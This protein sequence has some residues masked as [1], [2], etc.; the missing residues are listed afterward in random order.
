MN[1]YMHILSA[2]ALFRGMDTEDLKSI[3]SC[4][5]ARTRRFARGE[6]IFSEGD[7]ADQLGIVL[8]GAV[9]IVR[10]D[11]YGGRSIVG[12]AEAGQL[13]GE[14]FAYAGVK[15]MPV[16]V[17]ASLDCE[18]LLISAHRISSPCSSACGFHNQMIFNLLHVMA[19]KNLM[20]TRKNEIT[21]QRS[22]RGKLLAYLMQEAKKNRS[23]TF[24]IPF[25]RQE[26]ADYLNVDRSGLSAEISRLR[27]EGVLIC[28][29]NRFTLLRPD[30]TEP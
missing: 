18:V 14:T 1:Q 5:G 11:Y 23:S 13:F 8:V 17:V 12:T 7:P 16:S 25:D 30:Y 27:R 29:K 6:T 21:S 28:T 15:V 19:A 2:C 3:L 9:Q 24:A 10:M 20:F 22:T 4:L 26:L